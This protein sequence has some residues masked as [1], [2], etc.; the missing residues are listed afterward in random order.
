MTAAVLR[1]VNLPP[2]RARSRR[3]AGRIGVGPRRWRAAPPRVATAQRAL[4]LCCRRRGGI[5]CRLQR[6]G[7]LLEWGF[8]TYERV[9]I[10]RAGDPLSV[11]IRIR[12]GTLAQVTPVA[13][14]SVSLSRRRGE[15]R[16]VQVRYQL[17]GVV[18]APVARD[19]AVGEL[20]VEEQGQLV[21]V[22]PVLSPSAGVSGIL[23]AAN[24]AAVC[25]PPGAYRRP[26]SVRSSVSASTRMSASGSS[27]ARRATAC[28]VS[29][30]F[31]QQLEGDSAHQVRVAQCF[32]CLQRPHRSDRPA[33]RAR[34]LH[35]LVP[36]LTFHQY[37]VAPDR[38]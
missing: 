20:I 29:P 23:T 31:G 13:G 24:D 2:G 27:S 37:R 26:R 30:P 18:M 38:R 19:Q 6:C 16:H 10:V 21:A 17:P 15:E 12:H 36:I 33:T 8:E 11:P 14:G 34:S 32:D 25:S 7:R 22:V 35:V 5:E 28:A 3:L 9:D 4:R 1:N